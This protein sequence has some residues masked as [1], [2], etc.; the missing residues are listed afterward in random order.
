MLVAVRVPLGRPREGWGFRLFTRRAGDF[1][2]ALVACTLRQTAGGIEG[3]RLAAGGIGATPVRLERAVPSGAGDAAWIARAV[4]EVALAA[5]IDDN[6]RIPSD[7]RREL[8]ESLIQD[9]LSDALE[10]A[11]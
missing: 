7:Y 5:P 8:L 9:A 11:A 6:E 1:A 2:L 10:R 3:L 4:G